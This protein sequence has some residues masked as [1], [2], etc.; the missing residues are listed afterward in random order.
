MKVT[1]VFDVDDEAMAEV[2][3]SDKSVEYTLEHQD[4][5][6]LEAEGALKRISATTSES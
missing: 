1:V 3:E 2:K 6:F 4:L 5:G